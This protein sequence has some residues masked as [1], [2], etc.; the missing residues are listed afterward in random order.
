[1]HRLQELVRLHR[2]GVRPRA[3]RRLLVMSPKTEIKYRHA[4]TTAGL[5][6]GEDRE[7]PS[8]DALRAA[9]LGAH[10]SPERPQI[11][12]TTDPWHDAIVAL[13]DKGV[14]PRAAW[15]KLRRSDPDF[16][17]SYDAIKRTYR[18]LRRI[19]GVRPQDVVIPVDTS[20]GD[21]AQVDFGYVG[22]F[23]DEQTGKDRKTWVFVMTLGFSRLMFA[24]LVFDQSVGTWLD[25]HRRAFEFFGSVPHVVVPDN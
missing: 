21:V 22:R 18:R 5:L 14:R 15:D 10:P 8:M 19:Q 11:Q 24:A 1:M 2:Q 23:F 17:A 4:L 3:V 6:A 20:P 25:L 9:V 12:S 7:L 13:F 16:G